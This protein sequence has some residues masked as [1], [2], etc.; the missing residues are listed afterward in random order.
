MSLLTQVVLVLLMLPAVPILH[1]LISL[2]TRKE[3]NRKEKTTPFCVNLM[4][5]QVLYRAAQGVL[6]DYICRFHGH[7][8]CQ[9]NMSL[10]SMTG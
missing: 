7:K 5:S 6:V 1:Q 10:T 8:A 2:W 9:G 4:R 3:T